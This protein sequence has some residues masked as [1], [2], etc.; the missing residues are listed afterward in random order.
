MATKEKILVALDD[1]ATADEVVT[2]V[3]KMTSGQEGL[4]IGLLHFI[5]PLPPQLR[6]FRGA[7]D[8]KAERQLDRELDVKCAQWTQDAERAA[9]ASLRRATTLLTDSGRAASSIETTIRQI[10]NHEDLIGDIIGAAQEKQ[11]HTIVVGR[12][13]FPWLK[14][15]FQRHIADELVRKASGMT[16]WVVER[17]S[18]GK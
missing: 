8:P 10:E 18:P 5:P 15:L 16:I 2:Y 13:A 12:S 6:E 9:Q 3:A 7:E 14:E 4:A 11:C 1:D 17:S